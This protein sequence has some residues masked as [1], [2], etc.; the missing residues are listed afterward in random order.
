MLINNLF[1]YSLLLQTAQKCEQYLC[2]PLKIGKLIPLEYRSLL[3][4]VCPFSQGKALVQINLLSVSTLL[5]LCSAYAAYSCPLSLSFHFYY[6]L[7][8]ELS[9]PHLY[10]FK[11]FPSTSSSSPLNF[12]SHCRINLLNLT[13]RVF[14]LN[15]FKNHGTGKLSPEVYT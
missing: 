6:L 8:L 11:F 9:L 5:R 13:H 3:Q 4:C 15:K 7:I 14:K 1:C 2:Y 10:F 12:I